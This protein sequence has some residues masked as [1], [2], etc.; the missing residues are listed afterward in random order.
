MNG[1]KEHDRGAG[2]AAVQIPVG[3]ERRH[4]RERV[5]YISPSGTVLSS[6]E[7]VRMYL[8][9]EGACKCGLECPLILH[10]VFSFDPAATVKQ[11]TTEDVKADEDVT[12]LCNHKRKVVAMATLHKSMETPRP[13]LTPGIP[14]TGGNCSQFSHAPPLGLKK[15]MSKAPPALAPEHKNAFLSKLLAAPGPTARPFQPGQT[16]GQRPEARPPCARQRHGSS[17]HRQMSPRGWGQGDGVS[18]MEAGPQS[19]R[20]EARTHSTCSQELRPGSTHAPRR[21]PSAP[22]VLPQKP[23]A[24]CVPVARPHPPLRSPKS[25]ALKTPCGFAPGPEAAVAPALFLRPCDAWDQALCPGSDPLG[26]LRPVP[27]S[28]ESPGG[29]VPASGPPGQPQVSAVNVNLPSAA[30]PPSGRAGHGDCA[31]RS[32]QG[33]RPSSVSSSSSSDQ[34]GRAF[35]S[36][37]SSSRP[38]CRS[39][40][41]L[42]SPMSPL[43]PSPTAKSDGI[44]RSY[45]DLPSLLSSSSSSVGV[46][47]QS[48]LPA[49][50]ETPAQPSLLGMP[51]SQIFGHHNAAFFPASSLLSAAAKAQLASQSKAVAGEPGAPSTLPNGY[52]L[53]GFLGPAAGGGQARLTAPSPRDPSRRRKPATPTV[54]SMLRQ[55]HGLRLESDSPR[56]KVPGQAVPQTLHSSCSPANGGA[57]GAVTATAPASPPSFLP[58][59]DS[60]LSPMAPGL[61][62][63]SAHSL[64]LMNVPVEEGTSCQSISTNLVPGYQDAGSPLLGLV[65]QLEPASGSNAPLLKIPA[66]ALLAVPGSVRNVAN[67]EAVSPPASISMAGRGHPAIT[68][69]T[70]VLNPG[71]V[72]T[73]TVNESLPGQLP[74]GEGFPFISQDQVL[75]FGQTVPSSPGFPGTLNP[76]LLGPLPIPFP[77][78]QPQT[79]NQNPLN[80]VP[81]TMEGQ[82]DAIPNLFGLLNPTLQTALSPTSNDADGQTLQALQILVTALLQS[83]S[84]A[85]I[86]PLA[87]INL[88]LPDLTQQPPPVL[89]LPTLQEQLPGQPTGDRPEG[90]LANPLGNAFGGL[91]GNDGT[92]QPLL[93]PAA[94]GAP[95]WLG[96]NPQLLAAVLSSTDGVTSQAQV[97]NSSVPLGST[98]STSSPASPNLEGNTAMSA[99][100]SMLPLTGHG[101]I[102]ALMPHLL[103]PLLGASLLGDLSALNSSLNEPQLPGMQAMLN[104]NPWQLQQQQPLIQTLQGPLG[105]QLLPSQT[106][107]TGQANH[108]TNPLAC[109]F[110][111]VQLNM[112][113]SLAP[114]KAGSL[115]DSSYT[116]PAPSHHP[117]PEPQQNLEGMEP[118]IDARVSDGAMSTEP[119]SDCRQ[120]SPA[121]AFSTTSAFT[122]SLSEP[123]SRKGVEEGAGSQRAPQRSSKRK[124]EGPRG[125]GV[126]HGRGATKEH[127]CGCSVRANGEIS[128]HNG[129]TEEPRG[130]R[131][132]C[133]NGR[134]G[135]DTGIGGS[136]EHYRHRTSGCNCTEEGQANGFPLRSGKHGGKSNAQHPRQGKRG[137]DK[138]NPETVKTLSGTL[139]SPHRTRKRS[140][141]TPKM[142][143]NLEV[144]LQEAMMELDQITAHA[145]QRTPKEKLRKPMR[146]KQRKIIR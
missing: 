32:P 47:H 105:I 2:T 59:H 51:L 89:Q 24:P 26:L 127:R 13:S 6:V 146:N 86:L 90:L 140:K 84:P 66:S 123:G 99:S 43:P 42:S 79:L 77:V 40:R 17:D 111:N 106:P 52:P 141:N 31:A 34:G 46:G 76:S 126:S 121:P 15:V 137:Q 65:A 130:T 95:A 102:H 72:V 53:P 136:A 58:C 56:S 93:F 96:L 83:H 101:K 1:G 14:T 114:G 23:Q 7:Q 107:L 144:A 135:L 35:Q 104:G 71:V 49:P 55:S 4:D 38:L 63:P 29:T 82:G 92:S 48:Q 110:Q 27:A 5:A 145:D 91:S 12:K 98:A 117:A 3:W 11:R 16:L 19:P 54:L 25:P 78:S 94:P 112:G 80:L 21:N 119:G 129:C 30:L 97:C 131:R 134:C 118:C 60:Q 103:N 9:T 132:E 36:P 33:S 74:L 22:A 138:V 39:P 69:T 100:E 120:P 70:S 20:L 108:H 45:H 50:P 73:S 75:P 116:S 28:P 61:S 67:P 124:E 122:A 128:G 139:D 113:Q 62:C 81:T 64:L 143:S 115:P 44:L 133:V 88:P 8:L 10:K 142:S 109:L 85:A 37:R 57:S 41:T 68:K 87:S 125:T 18:S